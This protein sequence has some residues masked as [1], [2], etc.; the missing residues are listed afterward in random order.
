MAAHILQVV[1]EY[2]ERLQRLP[3]VPKFS[4]ERGLVCD[5]CAPNR[6]FF[7]YL[8]RDQAMANQFMKE[9]GL[10]R[11]KMQCNTCGQDM[12]WSADSNRYE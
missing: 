3:Y 10:L 6:L 11:S 9:I 4:Y 1:T 8:F 2:E 12:K 7:N 5:D